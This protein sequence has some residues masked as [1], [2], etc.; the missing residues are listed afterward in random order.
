ME[1]GSVRPAVFGERLSRKRCRGRGDLNIFDKKRFLAREQERSEKTDPAAEV[2]D[3]VAAGRAGKV[4]EAKAVRPR[5]EE[6]GVVIKAGAARPELVAF[7]H[8]MTLSD[9][10]NKDALL[11]V[12]IF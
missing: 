12:L 6:G 3:R 5:R 11:R 4:G 2:A 1:S 10:K 8:V 7:F 9:D